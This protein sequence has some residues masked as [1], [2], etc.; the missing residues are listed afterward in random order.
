M[1][2]MGSTEHWW[3]E[4]STEHWWNDTDGEYGALVE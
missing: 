4:G 3:N 2:L 1:I